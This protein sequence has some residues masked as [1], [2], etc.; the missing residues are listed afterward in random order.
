MC[1]WTSR[2]EVLRSTFADTTFPF[3]AFLRRFLAFLANLVDVVVVVVSDPP[4]TF[5]QRLEPFT[6]RPF[7]S[8][9]KATDNDIG[10]AEGRTGSCGGCCCCGDC[11]RE[12]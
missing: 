12:M 2:L 4:A 1:L 11:G 9:G 5:S 3:F 6:T 8:A 10:D 7:P